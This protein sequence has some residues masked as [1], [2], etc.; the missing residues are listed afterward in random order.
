RLR[1]DLELNAEDDRP[2]ILEQLAAGRAVALIS[3]A[4]TPLISEPGFKLVRDAAAA[5]H[6]VTAVPG[7]SAALAALTVAGLPT[8]AFFFAGF[9]PARGGA[10]RSRLAELAAIPATLVFFEAPTRTADT[11][12]D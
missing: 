2:R 10:R 1:P 8:D 11:L 9:L 6:A 12:A 5:G 4:G 7:P 3:A